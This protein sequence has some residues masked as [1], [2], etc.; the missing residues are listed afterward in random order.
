[1]NFEGAKWYEWLLIILLAIIL[2]PVKAVRWLWNKATR[3]DR[4]EGGDE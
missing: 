2:L 3:R 4:K 1:M